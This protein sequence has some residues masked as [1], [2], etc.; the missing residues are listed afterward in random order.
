MNDRF[1]QR[2]S[3]DLPENARWEHQ[4]APMAQTEVPPPIAE[5][6]TPEAIAAPSLAEPEQEAPVENSD[7]MVDPVTPPGDSFSAFDPVTIAAPQTL[8]PSSETDQNAEPAQSGF[9][10][11][12]YPA[13]TTYKNEFNG[14]VDKLVQADK[15]EVHEHGERLRVTEIPV[16]DLEGNNRKRFVKPAGLEKIESELFMG[17]RQVALLAIEEGGRNTTARFLV[18][19]GSGHTPLQIRPPADL[20]IEAWQLRKHR[21]SAFLLDLSDVEI[22]K[23]KMLLENLSGLRE[24]LRMQGSFLVVVFGEGD[25]TATLRE[26]FN[27]IDIGRPDTY[28]VLRNQLAQVAPSVE[29]G[30]TEPVAADETASDDESAPSPKQANVGY[31]G[32]P[33]EWVTFARSRGLLDD[34]PPAEAVRLRAA[35]REALDLWNGLPQAGQASLKEEFK[36]RRG[37]QWSGDDSVYAEQLVLD[38]FQAW[39]TE[40]DLWNADNQDKPRLRAFQLAVAVVPTGDPIRI[41]TEA[42]A[43]LQTLTQAKLREA[44]LDDESTSDLPFGEP[45]LS[46]PGTRLLARDSMAE[47]RDGKVVFTR[48]GFAEAVV[49]YFWNDWP[50]YRS[51]LIDWLMTLAISSDFTTEEQSKLKRHIGEFAVHHAQERGEFGFLYD[52]VAKWAGDDTTLPDAAIL[53]EQAATTSGIASQVRKDTRQWAQQ[54]DKALRHAVAEMCASPTFALEHPRLVTTRLVHLMERRQD[55]DDDPVLDSALERASRLLVTDAHQS[56]TVLARLSTDAQ[57][58][59][60]SQRKRAVRLF[61]SIAQACAKDTATPVLIPRADGPASSR[62]LLVTLWASTL[63]VLKDEEAK[64]QPAFNAWMDA[65]APTEVEREVIGVFRGAIA[66]RWDE[67]GEAD[68]VLARL[69]GRW[70]AVTLLQQER[71]KELDE[72]LLVASRDAMFE[73]THQTFPGQRSDR[74]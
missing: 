29:S 22:E 44:G 3:E 42:T 55:G 4:M 72:R 60:P 13:G 18:S 12:D 20:T 24:T 74:G 36:K 8:R 33:E 34:K 53:L 47:L 41:R 46:G 70:R 10:P 38:R 7:E 5:D 37:V 57:S 35:I 15:V 54:D 1:D 9:N 71:A 39:S 25:L 73:I 16:D 63:R 6:A 49:R 67:A 27:V 51:A 61:L 64:I 11:E 62:R 2:R 32:T 17:D 26:R 23:P 56:S 65:C 40:L 50:E 58:E 52:V 66:D 30:N 59:N 45:V 14:P 21:E 43:L 28:E 68:H 31:A 69:S 19:A 48:P